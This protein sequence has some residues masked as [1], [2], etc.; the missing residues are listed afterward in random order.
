MIR[1]A[2]GASA[3]AAAVVLTISVVLA[4]L[5][6]VV[7]AGAN[8]DLLD[9]QV[10]QAATVLGSSVQAIQAQ[11][12]DAG[13]VAAATDARPEQFQ[14]FAEGRLTG[15]GARFVSVSLLRLDD[16]A[17][18]L[19]ATEGEDPL[20]PPGGLD[21]PLLT[22]LE[23]TGRLT[24]VGI[25]PGEP[26]RLGYALMPAGDSGLV[27][28]AEQVLDADRVTTSPPEDEAFGGLDFAVYLGEGTDDEQLLLTTVPTP[29]EGESETAVTP[30][31]TTV[32][33]VVGVT[34]T[35]LIGALASALPWIVLGVGVVLAGAAVAIVQTL[36]RRRAVAEGLAVENERL[37]HQQRGIAATLQHAMLPEVPAVQGLEV[38]ARYVAGVDDLEVG[39]DWFDLIPRG[40]GS[41]VFVVGDISGR[42]LP[43]ATT[44]AALRFA[45]RAHLADGDD[46]GAVMVKLRRLLRIDDDHQFA[47][48]LLGELDAGTGRLRLVSAGHFPPLLVTPDGVAQVDVP[49]GPPVG[50]DVA[51]PPQVVSVDVPAR[52]TLLAF[53]DGLVERKGEV[54]DAGLDRLRSAAAQLDGRPLEDQLDDLMTRLAVA[55]R[56]DDTVLVGLRWTS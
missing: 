29:V 52:A 34:R 26:D 50:V 7:N 27:V 41:C 44:M 15:E 42:G 10:E 2:R 25:L 35:N 6:S 13:A 28:Y 43:A 23:P 1:T 53:T 33:T 54:I 24:V 55:G 51:C 20:L 18:E 31:G 5:A 38:G 21:S 14:E 45:V 16:G 12:S 48:V 56:R 22:G 11:L 30:F 4:W 9:R 39:G 40:P 37:Y 47:T 49:T 36:S 3:L 17:A 32:L 8:A 46:I 19:L